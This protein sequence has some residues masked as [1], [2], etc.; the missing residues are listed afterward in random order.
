[1]LKKKQL[2]RLLAIATVALMAASA[3]SAQYRVG[4]KLGRKQIGNRNLIVHV[5]V[6][7]P[8]GTAVDRVADRALLNR[9][10]S[11]LTAAPYALLGPVWADSDGVGTG[12]DNLPQYYNG[13]GDPTGAGLAAYGAGQA[14]W[15]DVSTSRFA[16]TAAGSTT[17]CPS[18]VE[19]CGSQVADSYNDVGWCNLGA[20]SPIFGGVLGVTWFEWND[21]N[22][23]VEADVCLNSDPTVFWAS[24]GTS[25]IDV[26]TVMV[27][28][29]GHV[30][31]LG[32]SRNRR[33]VMYASYLD[34]RRALHSD[35]IDGIS[36][37][38]PADD[39]GGE[40]PPNSC[41]VPGGLPL[42][43]ACTNDGDCCSGKCTGRPG[44]KVC[45]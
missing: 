19:E 5:T 23:M 41:V 22:I 15:T 28:E 29:L 44:A 6:A 33:A 1:M 20:L 27:H 17:R 16:F 13:A 39:G 43:S 45:R 37:L 34:V 8:I 18:L 12:A 14:A 31:T 3:A 30:A 2:F 32:H 25:D 40:D 36:F 11:P 4:S 26:H 42:G 7:V 10:A 24:D 9:G 38:Y 21:D 35:D